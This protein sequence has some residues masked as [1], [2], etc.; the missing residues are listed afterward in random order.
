MKFIS[1]ILA[2]IIKVVSNILKWLLD[3]LKN[4]PPITPGPHITQVDPFLTYPGSVIDIAGSGFAA[5]L[6]G[7]AIMVGGQPARVIRASATALKVIASLD[8]RDGPITVATGSNTAVSPNDFKAKSYPLPGSG[9]DG[10]PA[11]FEGAP[12]LVQGDVPST[13]TLRVLVVLVNPTDVV[14]A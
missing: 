7:N 5:T 11:Y 3:W 4:Q 9:E 14:P 8:A 12:N 10:P 13:G 2:A 1:R 6:D